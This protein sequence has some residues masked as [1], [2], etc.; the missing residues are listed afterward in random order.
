MTLDNLG[1]FLHI[2]LDPG[3]TDYTIYK[4]AGISIVPIA[5]QILLQNKLN[6]PGT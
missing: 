2:K 4:P 6:F 5:L 3:L 1:L